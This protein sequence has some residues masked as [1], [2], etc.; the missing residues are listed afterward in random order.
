MSELNE[1]VKTSIE[2][3]KAFEPKNGEGYYLAFSGGK[4]SVVTKALMDMAGVKYDAH[5]RVT[6]VDPP[7]LVRFIKQKHP[8]VKQEIPHDRD[9]KP[10]TMWNLIPRKMMPPTRIARYCCAELKEDGGDGRKCVT[11]VRW[12]ESNNRRQNQGIVTI[13]D[14]KATKELESMD[15]RATKRGGVVLTNDN[16][17]SRMMVESCYKRHKLTVNPIIEWEDRD[18]WDFILAEKIPYCELYNEGFHR[19]GCIGCPMATQQMRERKLTRWPKYKAAYLRAFEKML[20]RRIERNK[21]DP[22]RPVWR[23]GGTDIIGKVTAMDVYNWW[24]EYDIL[25]GQINLFEEEEE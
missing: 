13:F 1:K 20:Q 24:M 19:I 7:E 6:S 10:I 17:E 16:E 3:L 14:K 18:V 22:S 9:G 12:A 4:D 21:T 11:G 25:P 2:R 15:F 8:D 5:Y 23:T